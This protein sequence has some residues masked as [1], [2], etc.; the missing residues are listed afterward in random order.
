MINWLKLLESKS[1]IFSSEQDIEMTLMFQKE[2]AIG[3]CARQHESARSRLSIMTQAL[4]IVEEV[5]TFE[6][7]DFTPSPKVS[8][9]LVKFIPRKDGFMKNGKKNI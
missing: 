3:I 9:E 6:P 2:V 8:A 7:K 4:C 1:G 5:M